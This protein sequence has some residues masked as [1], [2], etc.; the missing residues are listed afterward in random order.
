MLKLG[1]FCRINSPPTRE[2]RPVAMSCHW[3]TR[4]VFLPPAECLDTEHPDCVRALGQRE[5]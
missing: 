4:R 3:W 5:I 2:K 1:G